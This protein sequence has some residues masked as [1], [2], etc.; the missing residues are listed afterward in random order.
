MRAWPFA[1][2]TALVLI[3]CDDGGKEQHE[4]CDQLFGDPTM[5]KCLTLEEKRKLVVGTKVNGA[6]VYSVDAGPSV[7]TTGPT[8]Y[9]CCYT[10][11][12]ER[13]Q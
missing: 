3:G 2:V 12:Q 6:Q 1:L 5:P 7:R 8:S 10:L 9:V 11:T 13:R 4:S